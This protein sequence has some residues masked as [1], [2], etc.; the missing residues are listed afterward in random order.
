METNGRAVV[1]AIKVIPGERHV[2][3]EEGTQAAWLHELLTPHVAE[4]AVTSGEKQRGAKNDERDAF[5]LAERL[6]PRQL[7]QHIFKHAGPFRARARFEGE[8]P[9]MEWLTSHR[10]A[11]PSYA[12]SE[13]PKRKRWPDHAETEGWFRLSVRGQRRFNLAVGVGNGAVTEDASWRAARYA[14]RQN[15]R[16]DEPHVVSRFE[17]RRANTRRSAKG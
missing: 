4:V 8:N 13:L 9:A 7:K 1:E 3:M 6:R 10:E 5:A 11:L 15:W 17:P 2:V 12:P 14:G 16:S